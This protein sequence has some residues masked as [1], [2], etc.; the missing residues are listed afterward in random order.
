MYNTLMIRNIKVLIK[1]KNKNNKMKRK[2][3]VESDTVL[4]LLLFR[5]GFSL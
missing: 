3:P 4:N 1:L 2:V 5:A